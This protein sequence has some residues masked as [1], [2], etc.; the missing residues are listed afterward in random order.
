MSKSPAVAPPV[1]PP[2]SLWRL[3]LGFLMMGATSLGGG[4]IAYLRT[5]LVTRYRWLDD[6]TFV[7]LM[8]ISQSLPGL[9]A[10]NMSI[11]AGDRLRGWPGALVAALGMCL[12][13]A[14]IMTAAAFAYGIGGD[15]PVS[16]AFLHAIAA[17]AVGLITVVLVQLGAKM[18]TEIADYVFV[19]LTAVLVALF[20]VPV[21]YALIGVGALAIWWHRPRS[22]GPHKATDPQPNDPAS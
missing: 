8:A 1:A 11:L 20:H 15:D 2:P 19:A 3:F 14:S 13:G 16:K 21:P 5:G 6:A 4:V 12:P 7:E 9:N 22:T 18:L 17:G 10:T